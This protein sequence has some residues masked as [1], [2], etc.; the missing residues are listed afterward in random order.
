MDRDPSGAFAPAAAGQ[1][2][3][4]RTAGERRPSETSG[5][6]SWAGNWPRKRGSQRKTVSGAPLREEAIMA[7]K[8][9][10]IV[11]DEFDLRT[12]IRDILEGPGTRPPR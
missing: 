4:G 9:V 5:Y 3:A 1:P 8:G 11:D 7:R 2:G 10:L 6:G 12:G